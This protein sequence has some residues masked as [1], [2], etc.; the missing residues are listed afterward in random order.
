V[1]ADPKGLDC[2]AAALLPLPDKLLVDD[3]EDTEGV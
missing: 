2:D 1:K 3:T